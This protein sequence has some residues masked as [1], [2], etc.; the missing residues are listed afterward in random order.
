M[1]VKDAMTADVVTVE[2]GTSLKDAAR[3]L[4]ERR[5][6]GLPVVDG[7][8]HLLGMISEADILY[9][10]RGETETIGG[11]LAWLVNSHHLAE[12]QKLEA[13]VVGEAMTSPV[14]TIG[15][16]RPVTAAASLMIDRGVNRLPVV[17]REGRLLGSVTRADLVKAFARTDAEVAEDIRKDVV[18][19]TMWL[20]NGAVQVQVDDGEVTLRGHIDQRR[21]AEL[22]PKLVTHVPG[23]VGVHSELT[24]SEDE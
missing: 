6:S 3:T 1:K 13:R 15:P 16:E 9:R 21:D 17:D 2:P 24:W 23:V 10:E 18:Q 7:E 5:I 20:D 11:P 12:L 14:I 22:L 4:V 8:G 19:H